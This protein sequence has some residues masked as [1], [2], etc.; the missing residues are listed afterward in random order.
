MAGRLL[1]LMLAA[2]A[3]AQQLSEEDRVECTVETQRL[4]HCASYTSPN[5]LL[6]AKQQQIC[7]KAV[8][9]LHEDGCFWCGHH[10]SFEGDCGSW[11]DAN[12]LSLHG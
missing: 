9:S 12:C 11:L 10:V 1:L 8:R 7:C 3:S 5:P 2:S 4:Y 6:T